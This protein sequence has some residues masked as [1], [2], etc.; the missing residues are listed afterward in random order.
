MNNGEGDIGL[1]FHPDDVEDFCKQATLLFTDREA[2]ERIAENGFQYALNERDWRQNA[3]RY[4][5]V[6]EYARTHRTTK[7]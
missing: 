2:R 7:H 3:K 5:P 4:I 1:L 6:Y